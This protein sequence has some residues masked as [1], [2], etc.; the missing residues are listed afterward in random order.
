MAN[1]QSAMLVHCVVS[2]VSVSACLSLSL[3]G[4][5]LKLMLLWLREDVHI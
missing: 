2:A 4:H 1:G 5:A 3:F